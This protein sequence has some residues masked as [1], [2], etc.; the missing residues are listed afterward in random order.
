[1]TLSLFS[2][3]RDWQRIFDAGPILTGRHPL[4][5]YHGQLGAKSF[6][7]NG[8]ICCY[9]PTFHAGYPKTPIFDSASRPAE[10][11]LALCGGRYSPAAYKIG[12][13]VLCLSVPWVIWLSARS[14]GL[15]RGISFVACLAGQMTWWSHVGQQALQAGDVD[16]LL[17]T[18]M[19]L[20]QL[21]SLRR[22]HVV[23]GILPL[24][25]ITLTAI[26]TWF[27]HPL[28]ALASVPLFLVYYFTVGLKHRLLWHLCLF[29]ALLLGPAVN[30]FWLLDWLSY[31]WIRVGPCPESCFV[32]CRSI[33]DLWMA[34]HWGSPAERPQTI[35][36]L[37]VAMLGVVTWHGKGH[38][39]VARMLGVAIGLFFGLAVAGVLNESVA[40][41]GVVRLLFPA[42]LFACLPFALALAGL[43]DFCRRKCFL[44]SPVV[45]L[46]LVAVALAFFAPQWTSRRFQELTAPTPLEIGLGEQREALITELRSRTSDDARILWEDRRS[47]RT[48]SRWTALLPLLCERSFIGGLDPD[49]GIEHTACGL[50]DGRL[51]QRTNL[52]H[53]NSEE[54]LSDYCR[55]YNIGWIVCFTPELVAQFRKLPLVGEPVA[56][57]ALG[58]EVPYLFTLR[59]TKSFALRGSIARMNADPRGILLSEVKPEQIEG[60]KEGEIVLSLHYQA[61]MRVSPP[62]VRIE[63]AVD[64]HDMIPFVRLRVREPVGSVLI[65]WDGTR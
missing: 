13:A 64:L 63:K 61:G 62:R 7:D 19:L 37:V 50:I 2:R 9:D 47:A 32:A 22:F 25:S 18:L 31:S 42:L 23:P 40:R 36:V 6:L 60:E 15:C 35:I 34:P 39:P 52:D 26:V 46:L 43:L 59:R 30:S 57:P 41:V 48:R 58:D 5:L 11:L 24:M 17:A 28:L 10:L 33:H 20:L 3:D 8:N 56:L 12:L 29:V 38:R 49:S 14:A 53:E 44:W 21:G 55:R 4:H 45:I 1:M 16:L 51:A 27:A 54:V 65:T